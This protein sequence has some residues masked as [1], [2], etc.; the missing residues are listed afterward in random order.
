[1]FDIKKIIDFVKGEID[2]TFAN[3]LFIAQVKDSSFINNKK[4]F[5]L[6]N[7]NNGI[8][9][10]ANNHMFTGVGNSKGIIS[11]PS[12][13]DMVLVLNLFRN[14]IILGSVY[15][16]DSSFPDNQIQLNDDELIIVAKTNGNYIKYTSDNGI[17][18]VA[19]QG[20]DGVSGFTNHQTSAQSADQTITTETALT[21]MT[22]T[23]NC[24]GK[25]MILATGDYLSYSTS[26]LAW[27][28]I[29]VKVNGVAQQTSTVGIGQYSGATYAYGTYSLQIIKDLNVGD[30]ITVYGTKVQGTN[31][32]I[33]NG[34]GRLTIIQL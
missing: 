1:M 12:V 11:Y 14:F 22:L 23:A 31:L 32:Q 8:E 29:S 20:S 33:F 2:S 26:N 10:V 24:K 5:T 28:T 4:T 9:I 18:A 19:R 16:N 13:G 6:V 17:K 3:R 15:D 30:V 27:S 25:F 7:L 34:K 21:G